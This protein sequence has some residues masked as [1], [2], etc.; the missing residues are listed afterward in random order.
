MKKETIMRFISVPTA[1][2]LCGARR[3]AMMLLMTMLTSVGA[4]AAPAPLH[5]P[6]SS[7]GNGTSEN[8]YKISST[9]DLDKLAEDVNNGNSY[10]GVYFEL[11][12]NITYS[13]SGLGET[14]SNFTPIGVKSGSN[15]YA[16]QGHFNGNGRT[17]SG[18]RIYRS[19][20]GDA[21]MYLGI[22]GN[23]RGSEGNLA[24]VKRVTLKNTKITGYE[25]CGGI[26][27]NCTYTQIT[28]CHVS[29][30]VTIHAMIAH[31]SLHG[32]IVGNTYLNSEISG[33]TSD[34][35]ISMAD[36]LTY[37]SKFGAIAGHNSA[38]IKDCLALPNAKVTG[39]FYVGAIVGHNEGTLTSN[40]YTRFGVFGV[41]TTGSEL[42]KWGS[43]QEGAQFGKLTIRYKP[44]DW[45]SSASTSYTDGLS[46]YD[47][48]INYGTVGHN[49]YNCYY[50]F[51]TM[52]DCWGITSGND[53]SVDHPYIIT[54]TTGLDLLADQVNK[55][56]NGYY[57]K[58]FELGADITY[59]YTYAWDNASND[60]ADQNNYTP[61]GIQL[62]TSGSDYRFFTGYFDG[63]GHTVSGIRYYT[64]GTNYIDGHKGLFARA[65]YE[66]K[67]VTLADTR[68]TG[69]EYCGG[70]AGES[71]DNITNCHVG[72]DVVIRSSNYHGGIVGEA[73]TNYGITISG[74]TSAASSS[75][76]NYG[77]I[78]GKIQ[79]KVTVEDCLFLGTL[80]TGSSNVGA[81]VGNNDGGTLTNNYHTASGVGGVNGADTDGAKYAVSVATLP[82]NI[83][84]EGTTYGEDTYTGITAYANGLKY[85]SK[86]YIAP[87]VFSLADNSD[88]STALSNNN[89]KAAIVTLDGRTLYCDGD[90]NTLC[91][92]FSLT[93]AEIAAS[94]LASF[95]IKELATSSNLNGDCKLTLNFEDATTIEAGKPYLVKWAPALI[96][97]NKA[98]WN[99]FCQRV[100]NNY[101][102]F[103]GKVVK[104]ADDYDNSGDAITW[105]VGMPGHPF[106]GT[107]DGNGRTLTVGYN[108]G[109]NYLAPFRYV[110]GAT[111]KNLT[112]AGS[113]IDSKKLLGGLV[114]STVGNTTISNCR[115]SATVESTVSGDGTVGGF[116]AII[117]NGQTT[118]E[119]C[120]FDGSFVG[121]DT[122]CWSGF[123]GW[124]ECSATQS[125][126]DI[127]TGG[128]LSVINSLFAPTSVTISSHDNNCTVY[129]SRPGYS[130]TLTKCY[131]KTTAFN[132]YQG[133]NASGMSKETLLSNLGSG[134]EISGEN[135]VPKMNVKITGTDIVNPVF[136]NVIIDNTENPVNFTGGSFVGN[137]APLAINDA[138]RKSIVLL[139]AGNKLGYANTDR[140]LGAFRAYFDIPSVAGAPAISSYELNFGEDDENTTGIIE[141]NTNNTNLTNKAEGVFDLQGRKVANPS[142][143]LYI[144]NGKKIVI[145]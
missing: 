99:A 94:P 20:D 82:A 48:G 92:P 110:D 119:N 76:N 104:L 144:V 14:D 91:L 89:G 40:A 124:V 142:K 73:S 41:G 95:T 6:T 9:S 54:T 93:A 132:T 49:N 86:Y 102:T 129:R 13:T 5:F 109:T 7:G 11:T 51:T 139:A 77:G 10:E 135:V 79:S 141:V 84:V 65:Y 8:P 34:A 39:N 80:L 123:V 38:T 28:D 71:V 4:W 140:T 15:Y 1:K 64:N 61:I 113:F 68:I 44:S 46:V 59:S 112:I 16:F 111:I 3:V 21:D 114:G 120:L 131:Y 45:S 90:W 88:N 30:D 107:F 37:C 126:S 81:I 17:I 125:N 22:F 101:E 105:T 60:N 18:I 58:Y 83:G 29:D 33:C 128:S 56:T 31:S 50:T 75:D 19:G 23:V 143:G 32:G 42:S 118:I 27:G 12:Q 72:S 35:T 67:N 26:A 24:E 117:D 98:D 87:A 55:Q 43:D 69:H 52:T 74:C 63:K 134:W 100:N 36:G 136:E 96:I 130:P 138:N 47:K 2:G 57:Q 116:V 145:K 121:T 106:K 115:V 66:V 70:I 103:E 133:D 25:Y 108:T 85:N 78:A 127:G 137:Y 53:G 97:K 62:S 122:R